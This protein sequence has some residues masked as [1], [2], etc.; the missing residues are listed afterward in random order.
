MCRRICARDVRR[1][2]NSLPSIYPGMNKTRLGD[3]GK[4]SRSD[5]RA[6][7]HVRM[8]GAIFLKVPGSGSRPTAVAFKSVHSETAPRKQKGKG[9]VAASD[10][11]NLGVCVETVGQLRRDGQ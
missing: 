10:L 4:K 8:K 5:T 6:Q 7:G 11:H 1:H 3:F 9:T 2:A